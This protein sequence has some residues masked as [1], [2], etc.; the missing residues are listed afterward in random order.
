MVGADG[1]SFVT[2]ER[3][4]VEAAKSGNAITDDVRNVALARIHSLG[5]VALGDDVEVGACA[6]IDRGTMI[7]TRV[8]S[9]TKIDNL[10]Q[11][12][13]NCQIGDHCMLCGHVGIAGS[14]EIG[15]RVVLAG[16]VGI[17][18]H[19]KVGE[20]SVIGAKSG[21]GANVPPRSVLLG[22]PA[23]PSGETVRIMAAMRKVPDLMKTVR[24][25]KK[26]LSEDGP[27]G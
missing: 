24:E 4:S 20:D 22:Y 12:G 11:I 10:V 18:D 1:F 7:D 21:V 25:L 8:G 19:I 13:H 17:A 14:V 23:L 26:R 5:S 16:H 9:G 15:D 27:T 2:P 3:G 6:T